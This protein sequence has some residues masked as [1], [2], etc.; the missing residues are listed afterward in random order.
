[1][2]EEYQKTCLV[3]LLTD[4]KYT[5]ATI[6]LKPDHVWNLI[7]STL[8]LQSMFNKSKYSIHAHWKIRLKV[9]VIQQMKSCILIILLILWTIWKHHEMDIML[10][11]LQNLPA[12][13]QRELY[14]WRCCTLAVGWV[15]I[16][17]RFYDKG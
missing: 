14:E 3:I 2:L 7:L 4:G 8:V 10:Q 1:M 17:L 6:P 16:L 5:S 11:S 15:L 9:V 13:F 12:C